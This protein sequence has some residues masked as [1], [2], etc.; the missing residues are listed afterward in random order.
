MQWPLL[1]EQQP[2]GH[3]LCTPCWQRL[4]PMRQRRWRRCFSPGAA[5][6]VLLLLLL[7][8]PLLLLLLPQLLLLLLSLLL[9]LLTKLLLLLLPLLLLLLLLLWGPLL[10]RRSL[11]RCSIATR[12][13]PSISLRS[14]ASSAPPVT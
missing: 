14:P 3:S 12:A 5:A 4:W 11:R 7:L 8:L 9:L 13:E 2:W 1:L 10:K 6:S